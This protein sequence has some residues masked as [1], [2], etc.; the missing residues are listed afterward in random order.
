MLHVTGVVSSDSSAL[1]HKRTPVQI[2]PSP[3]RAI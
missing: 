1:R 2:V 3:E